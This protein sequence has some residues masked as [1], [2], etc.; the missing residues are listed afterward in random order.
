GVWSSLQS[1]PGGSHHRGVMH[2]WIV[3][4]IR[5]PLRAGW[6][7]LRYVFHRFAD[8]R[9]PLVAA[10]LT[11]TSLLSLVPFM[12]LTLSV[13]A[14][15]PAFHRLGDKVKEFVFSNFV[16]AAR[17][18]VQKT[19]LDFVQ[20]ASDLQLVGVLLFAAAALLLVATIDRILNDVWRVPRRRGGVRAFLLY[21]AVITLGPVLLGLSIGLTSY[22][23]SFPMISG[24]VA[25]F[26]L[27]R[28][29]FTFIP[30]ALTATALTFIYLTV[31]NRPV[32]FSHAAGGG[33]VAAVLFELAKRGFALYV[34]QVPT[35]KLVFGALAAVPLFVLWIYLSWLVV[36][37]GAEISHGLAVGRFNRSFPARDEFTIS[38]RVLG[39]LWR[40]YQ[41]GATVKSE[42]LLAL[43]PEVAEETLRRVLSA[44]EEAD[45][46]ETQS[47]GRYRLRRDLRRVTVSDLYQA[48]PWSF[49]AG[50]LVREGTA[51]GQLP[52]QD[53]AAYR[54]LLGKAAQVL[55]GALN[56]PLESL[57]QQPDVD[58]SSRG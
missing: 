2:N 51:K 27:K 48:L 46:V 1:N 38:Y 39:H 4:Q 47:D 43:E 41:R 7:F 20:K 22:F 13:F 53:L 40:A 50:R 35:Y 9:C 30:F 34:G 45:F 3:L 33:V 37:L 42:Q 23:V 56:V 17:E 12:T 28:L 11:L 16:P 24:A 52:D 54:Q 36:L 15:F 8:D 57:Y 25:Q 5:R 58:P 14:A 44:L 32:R 19:L 10:A 21:W 18:A 26:G 29:F 55:E 6:P 31:P 49:P